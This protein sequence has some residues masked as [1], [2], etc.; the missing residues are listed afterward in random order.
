MGYLTSWFRSVAQSSASHRA[1]TAGKRLVRVLVWV[2]ASAALSVAGVENPIRKLHDLGFTNEV[3]AWLQAPL[4]RASGGGVF[5]VAYYGGWYG[6]LFRLVPSANGFEYRVVHLFGVSNRDGGTRG[7]VDGLDGWLY[8]MTH[9]GGEVGFGTI[10]R[11]RPDGT[12]STYERIHSFGGATTTIGFYPRVGLTLGASPGVL[13]GATSIRSEGRP[14]VLFRIGGSVSF[15]PRSIVRL[16]D[17][18]A[19]P[20]ARVIPRLGRRRPPL[21]ATACEDGN[22]RTE[23]VSGCQRA[24]QEPTRS[25]WGRFPS[26]AVGCRRVRLTVRW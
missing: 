17:L 24:E 19:L 12:D 25:N 3:G 22:P 23:V 16:E 4:V 1:E 8:G 13:Y 6:C 2:A 14:G 20:G 5:G 10:F 18:G 9:A 21:G 15:P 11:I 7:L 26:P